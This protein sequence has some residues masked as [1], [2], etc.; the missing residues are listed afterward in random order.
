VRVLIV[1]ASLAGLSSL[2]PAIAV[3]LAR[4]AQL[5][6]TCSACHNVLGTGIGPDL[7]GIYGRK[8]AMTPGFDYSEALRSS[9]VTWTEANLRAFITNPQEFIKGT[10]MTFPGYS[11]PADVEDVI[12]FLKTQ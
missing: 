9:G 1:A 3:D 2:T 11:N 7:A 6:Q 4:G 5:F 8:A 12:A 10:R